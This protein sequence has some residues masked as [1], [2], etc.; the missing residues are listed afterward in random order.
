MCVHRPMSSLEVAPFSSTH[1]FPHCCYNS[2]YIIPCTRF[3]VHFFHTGLNR[4]IISICTTECR[5]Y[6]NDIYVNSAGKGQPKFS[7]KTPSQ[8]HLV[9]HKC[10]QS[11]TWT[12]FSPNISVYR[13]RC[14][15]KAWFLSTTKVNT[16]V[17]MAIIR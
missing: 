13:A 2:A 3:S 8:Y 6:E 14:F 9:H 12:S 4:D 10:R 15:P 17:S 16:C 5:W 1:L 11:S 7:M